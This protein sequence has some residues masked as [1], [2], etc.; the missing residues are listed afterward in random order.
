MIL[1]AACVVLT[2][3]A[4]I[5]S[6]ADAGAVAGKVRGKVI[7]EVLGEGDWWQ[8]RVEQRGVLA[9]HTVT[10]GAIT[11]WVRRDAVKPAKCLPDPDMAM[12]ESMDSILPLTWADGREAGDMHIDDARPDAVRSKQV[13]ER[14]GK[15]FVCFDRE[16]V[17][18]LTAH[19]C[20][21]CEKLHGVGS[22]GLGAKAP[23][24]PCD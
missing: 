24:N 19:V 7:A 6:Q 20:G 9:G 11:F 8:L 13:Q 22:V 17:D 14:D 18:G 15:R 2:A 21:A 4:S 5:Y 10:R 16:W 23:H 3:G 12:L 1:A